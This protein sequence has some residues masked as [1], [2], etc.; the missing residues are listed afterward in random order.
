MVKQLMLKP[1]KCIGCRTCEVIC[2]FGKIK[3]FNPKNSAITVMNFEEAAICVPVTC[4]QC[5]EPTC[6]MV[7]PMQAIYK[8]ESG[9]VHI[10]QDKCI[11]CKLCFNAC[12]LGNIGYSPVTHQ[13]FKCNYCHGAP[14]CAEFCPSGAIIY[15]EP[16]EGAGRKQAVAEH[17]KEVFG[18]EAAK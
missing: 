10:D 4:L 2:S 3:A 16:D 15:A 6:Q 7:C 9:I 5:E 12:A 18:E 8:D 1:E 17:F 14:L 11:G 13:V